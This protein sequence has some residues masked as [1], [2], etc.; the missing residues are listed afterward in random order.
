MP[1]MERGKMSSTGG[2]LEYLCIMCHHC[3]GYRQNIWVPRCGPKSHI[4]ARSIDISTEMAWIEKI[5]KPV[6]I[7]RNQPETTIQPQLGNTA[8]PGE[9]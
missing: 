5:G 8:R 7:R 3:I 4:L 9:T 2:E 6:E 1:E